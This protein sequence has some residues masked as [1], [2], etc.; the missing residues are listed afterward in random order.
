MLYLLL[1]SPSWSLTKY[2]LTFH[3]TIE[4]LEGTPS[5]LPVAPKSMQKES[6]LN[7]LGDLRDIIRD[8]FDKKKMLYPTPGVG[9]GHS[10]MSADIICLSIDPPFNANLTPNYPVFHYS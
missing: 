4:G 8:H 3:L 6:D 2:R 9:G 10:H 5:F 1:P 7:H